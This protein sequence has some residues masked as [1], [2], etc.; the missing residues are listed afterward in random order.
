MD[1]AELSRGKLYRTLNQFRLI[2]RLFSPARRLT[3]SLLVEDMV[4]RGL[5]SATIV[6]V[7][8]GAGDYSQWLSGYGQSRG[9]QLR[10]IALDIN[11]L[12]AVYA[13]GS[14]S[15][16]D[17]IQVVAGTIACLGGQVDYA[18]ANHV[19]HHLSS[20]EVG[21]TLTALDRLCRY[22][23]LI[24]DLQRTRR[25]YWGYTLFAL[26][27]L[28]RSYARSDGRL[29]IRRGFRIEELQQTLRLAPL[30]KAVQLFY[31]APGHIVLHGHAP[32]RDGAP[33]SG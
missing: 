13:K 26:F 10:I 2:N 14:C 18:V 24:T 16:F 27:F 6:D 21:A 29:S 19:L 8:S 31:C 9:L 20:Q 3:R 12:V 33:M 15:H 28:P 17:T 4:Q 7:G 1:G 32:Q 11:K 30:S 25:A 23:F 22:G 5:Q